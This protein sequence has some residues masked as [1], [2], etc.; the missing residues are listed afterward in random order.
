MF[1]IEAIEVLR[2]PQGTLFGKNTTGGGDQRSNQAAR[3]RGRGSRRTA[4]VWRLRHP[5]NPGRV[6]C[7]P[8]RPIRGTLC[9]YV[10]T[11]RRLLRKQRAIR[12]PWGPALLPLIRPSLAYQDR[13]TVETW[14]ADD[15]FSGRF[16]LLWEPTDNF[17]ALF[18]YEIIRD[19]GDTP[20]VVHESPASFLFP[21]W[22]YPSATGDPIENAGNTGRDD[23]SL[24][25]S[26]GHR[27]DVDGFYVNAQWDQGNYSIF[28]N[29]GIRDQES[30]LP[31]FLH[32]HNRTPI[33]VRC[34]P[35]RRPGNEPV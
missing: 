8:R 1:D 25:M 5:T 10:S 22:G 2:G 6:E 14:A 28:A 29:A 4:Q 27:V 30:R 21:I 34:H 13:A 17:N 7:A 18:Q 26:A 35:R 15:V 16:K 31:Q 11:V 20:P 19:E 3:P 33:P 24:N 32:G 9:R 12:A 23:L